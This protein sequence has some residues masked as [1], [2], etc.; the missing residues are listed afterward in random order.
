[1]GWIWKYPNKFSRYWQKKRFSAAILD[2]P[3]ETGSRLFE[4]IN[5]T[6]HYY[7]TWKFASRILKLSKL[8]FELLPKYD[9]SATI[10]NLAAA[11]AAASGGHAKITQNNNIAKA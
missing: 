8:V 11:K 10:L 3:D 1:M 5:C 2:F 9:V 7:Q 4:P 6:D